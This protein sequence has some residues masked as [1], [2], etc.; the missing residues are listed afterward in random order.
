MR[1]VV[2]AAEAS[3]RLAAEWSS[4]HSYSESRY[5]S[6][7]ARAGLHNVHK[8]G[9]LVTDPARF[10]IFVSFFSQFVRHAARLVVPV[11]MI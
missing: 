10:S 11:V 4:Q 5:R 2:A 8:F 9:A 6:S 3:R 7:L 1:H